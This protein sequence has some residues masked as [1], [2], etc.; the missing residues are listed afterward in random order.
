M[1]YHDNHPWADENPHVITPDNI[2][3][4]SMFKILS[5]PF[6]YHRFRMDKRIFF[7]EKYVYARVENVPL[8]I[9]CQARFMHDELWFISVCSRENMMYWNRMTGNTVSLQYLLQST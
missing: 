2:K 4:P 9:R 3:F 7:L 8:N 6:V 1:D 5:G